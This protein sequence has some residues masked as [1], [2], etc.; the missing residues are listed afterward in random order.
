METNDLEL[1]LQQKMRQGGLVVENEVK[2]ST[3]W[4]RDALKDG[5]K[6]AV[7]GKFGDRFSLDPNEFR[8]SKKKVQPNDI[9][10]GK[11]YLMSYPNPKLK[12]KL[13]YWDIFPLVI[14]F[15]MTKSG[16][17]L[18]MNLHYLGP[19]ARAAFL[20]KLMRFRQGKGVTSD[21]S[22]A[23]TYQLLNNVSRFPEV[24]PTI[25]SYIPGRVQWAVEVP[26]TEWPVVVF[27]PHSKFKSAT[28]KTPTARQVYRHS[29]NKMK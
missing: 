26:M 23:L 10:F 13:P 25:H 3:N 20:G 21:S 17:I 9:P 11:M 16:N 14:P 24:K 27:L 2:R 7:R 5:I 28:G 22:L 1:D 15:D 4:F 12:D 8:N 18:G 19:F 6:R 29:K